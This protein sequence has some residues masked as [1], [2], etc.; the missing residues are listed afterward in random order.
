MAEA[1][2][3]KAQNLHKLKNAGFNVPNFFTVP[4]SIPRK[5]LL[6][7]ASGFFT[8]KDLLAIRSS[9]AVEDRSDK[10]YAGYF[11]TE[12]A[13]KKKDL[14]KAFDRVREQLLDQPNSGII[15]QKFI[16][17]DYAGVCFMDVELKRSVINALP[18]ICKPVVEGWPCEHYELHDR[19]IIQQSVSG[20]Y[21]TQ[22]IEDLEVVEK[23]EKA[24]VHIDK[25]MRVQR[26]VQ[27]V[28]KT[29]GAPQDVEWGFYNDRLYI[30]QTRPIT[31]SIWNN[32]RDTMLFDSA[33]VGESYSG[34]LSPLTA[35]FA[36]L[37][38]G[39]VYRD[40]LFQ[41]GVTPHRIKEHF[42]VFAKLV[43]VVYGRLYYRLDNWYRM[44]AFLPGY[45][46]N[47]RN[48]EEMLNLN[49][50]EQID[51]SPYRPSFELWVYYYPLV[52]IKFLKFDQ[53]IGTF[54]K[55][56]KKT[57]DAYAAKDI[58]QLT[59]S[60]TQR[61]LKRL[62]NGILRKWYLTVEND[63]VMM[64][65]L[66]KLT[67][68]KPEEAKQS[69][70]EF[71]SASIDQLKALTTLS[72]ELC[73]IS[74]LEQALTKENKSEFFHHLQQHPS[75]KKQ[76]EDYLKNY[77]GRFA[78]ELKLETPDIETDFSH[79]AQLVLQFAKREMPKSYSKRGKGGI[80][81]RLFKKFASRREEF[82]LHRANM[83]GVIRKLVLQLGNLWT[84][85]GK[86]AD[87]HDIFYLRWEELFDEHPDKVLIS[88]RKLDEIFYKKLD[89][90][91][92]FKVENNT[93]KFEELTKQAG[94]HKA[95]GA[96][97]GEVTGKALI[98]E[99]FDVPKPDSFDILVTKRTD[100][101]WTSVMAMAKGIVVEH[102]G[103][104]S[105]ASIVARELGIPAVIGVEN[106]CKTFNTGD[107]LLVDGTKGNVVKL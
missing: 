4:V 34:V 29:F 40:L 96:S 26:A 87:P 1:L 83:F 99:E 62:V 82:R 106:A 79:F 97:K 2:G 47:K 36:A 27:K 93:W 88:Q 17:S 50:S 24:K 53:T 16:P 64:T 19:E 42:K 102:G 5:E 61:E 89:L 7:R 67:K 32:H 33:N 78:N 45:Q 105:H 13:V 8:E 85:Q 54:R 81:E 56:L 65:L 14:W 74:E 63:T 48:L 103:I 66:N 39:A 57:F 73:S 71:H 35:T 51:V 6:Q 25:I 75:L 44:M 49:I 60:Q 20:T 31:R 95:I 90:P 104:L 92:F 68:N 55:Q 80:W 69:L 58:S 100:P 91:A 77:G 10:S 3:K 22:V 72:K 18:G 9:A 30:L 21:K 23:T 15:I 46:A 52:L 28:C 43:D 94:A 37:I 101:G 70:F 59:V 107:T 98:L 86:L 38:Y 76:Y 11:H 12:I 41:S 84:Q